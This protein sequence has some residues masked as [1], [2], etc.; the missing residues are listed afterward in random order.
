MR[1]KERQQQWLSLQNVGQKGEKNEIG[2]ANMKSSTSD[3]KI[4][5]DLR[6]FGFEKWGDACS[7]YGK[8]D[9]AHKDCRLLKN[10]V[11]AADTIEV[12]T[13]AFFL[14]VDSPIESWIFSAAEFH[15]SPHKGIFEKYTTRNYSNAYFDVKNN[16]SLD[17]VKKS[18]VRV[19][20]PNGVRWIIHNVKHIPG[21]ARNLISVGQLEGLQ[22]LRRQRRWQDLRQRAQQRLQGPLLQNSGDKLKRVKVDLDTDNDDFICLDEFNAFWVSSSKD[23]SATKL[24]NTSTSNSSTYNTCSSNSS[25]YP[26]SPESQS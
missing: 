9:H 11:G 20:L 5:A 21:L 25:F 4:E 14:S 6:K 7:H 19:K 23:G 15:C 18:N 24:K 26:I 1:R 17:T 12:I 22:K 2:K 10:N 13:E 8:L 3:I 16:R